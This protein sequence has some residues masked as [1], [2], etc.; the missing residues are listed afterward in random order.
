MEGDDAGKAEALAI[1]PVQFRDPVKVAPVQT[2]EAKA[3]QL[4]GRVCG[5]PAGARQPAGKFRLRA[6]EGQLLVGGGCEDFIS[7]CLENFLDG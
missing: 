6:R 3:T 7:K 4:A 2:Q 1:A 5:R